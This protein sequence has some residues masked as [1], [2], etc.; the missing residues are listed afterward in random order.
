MP[1]PEKCS[2]RFEPKRES[3]AGYWHELIVGRLRQGWGHKDTTNWGGMETVH[4]HS[5][6]RAI[7]TIVYDGQAVPVLAVMGQSEKSRYIHYHY[8]LAAYLGVAAGLKIES[9]SQIGDLLPEEDGGLGERVLALAKDEEERLGWLSP[10]L[11]PHLIKL[12]TG[13]DYEAEYLPEEQPA[14]EYY[15]EL[16]RDKVKQRV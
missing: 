9:L 15:R 12:S 13:F 7:G 8:L 16:I 10:A 1:I 6:G 2:Y 4:L 11:I 3:S 14:I 5:G